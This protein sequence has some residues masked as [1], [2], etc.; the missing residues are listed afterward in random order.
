MTFFSRGD[1]EQ[2][3]ITDAVYA[4]IGTHDGLVLGDGKLTNE[5]GLDAKS[6]LAALELL[7]SEGKIKLVRTSR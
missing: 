1:A 7:E 3:K 5:T 6:I 4:V 2:S